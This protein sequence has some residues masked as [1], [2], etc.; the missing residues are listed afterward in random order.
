[1]FSRGRRSKRRSEDDEGQMPRKALKSNTDGSK[2]ASAKSPSPGK[3]LLEDDDGKS[4]R[5]ALKSNTD[6]SDSASVES[7]SPG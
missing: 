7:P 3:R 5:K 1:M 2:S 6:G 4:P